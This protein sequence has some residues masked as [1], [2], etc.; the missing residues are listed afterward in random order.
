MRH[1]QATR[2]RLSALHSGERNPFFGLTHTPEVRARLSENARH[3][4]RS[5][6]YEPAP[7]RIALPDE[8]TLAYV[9]G[10]IDAD[11]SIRFKTDHS[12]QKRRPRPRVVIYNTSR[13]L[14]EWWLETF[15][16][17]SVTN[18]NKGREQVLA[19]SIAGARDV[20]ALLAAVR[21]WLIVK[22]ADADIA[23]VFLR[24]KYTEE[25][26]ANG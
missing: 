14:I 11:G 16:H 22:G 10:L 26:V 9:A 25:V 19:W 2:E 6:T 4:N 20:Y 7:R 8:A 13:P 1:T 5:R 23:L 15:Q 24:E 12:T 3:R 21:P 17:G 18:G